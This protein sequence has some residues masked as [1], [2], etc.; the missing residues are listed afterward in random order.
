MS[1]NKVLAHFCFERLPIAMA[2]AIRV[3][4]GSVILNESNQKDNFLELRKIQCK[5]QF[6]RLRG[7]WE[8]A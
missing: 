3:L 4:N 5:S 8:D 2:A 6:R 7:L 1:Q